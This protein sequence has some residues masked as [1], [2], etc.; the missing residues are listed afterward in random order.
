MKK[1]YILLICFFALLIP[2]Q[3]NAYQEGI[4]SFYIDATVLEDGNMHMKELI[5]L[6]GSFNG[7]D[8]IINY[9]NPYLK[10]FNG[11][12]L[13]S[14]Y[15]SDIYNGTGIE[16][17]A[18]KDI[19]V[20]ESSG[21]NAI[22]QDG[23]I[24][25]EVTSASLGDYGKYVLTNNYNGV[26][27]RIYN[28]SKGKVRGFY[29][30][31]IIQNS[32]VLHQ[33]V[34]EAYLNLFDSLTEYVGYLEMQIHIPN[35]K[36]LLR[37]WA[38]GP[39]TGEIS[40]ESNELIKVIASDISPNNPIDVRFVFDKDVIKGQNKTTSVIALEKIIAVE[41]E[42]ANQANAEREAIKLE[43]EREAIS[44]VSKAESN[45]T[46]DNYENALISINYLSEGTL[47]TELLS[48]LQL[49]LEKVEAEESK[50]RKFFTTISIAWI[51][52]LL[53]LGK[54]FYHKYD[55]E[56]KAEF[57]GTYYRDFPAEYG[58]EILA[59]LLKLDV[60]SEELSSSLMNLIYKKAILFE[61]QTVGKRNKK[62]YLL[63]PNIEGKKLTLQERELIAFLLNDKA[64][65]LDEIQK[66]AKRNYE[67]FIS[68]YQIWKEQALDA[69]KKEQF[70]ES[71]KSKKV[72]CTIYALFGFG[73]IF[74]N[75]V[76]PYHSY[77]WLNVLIIS[78]SIIGTVYFL[79]CTKKTQ[80]GTDHYHKWMGLKK[81]LKDFSNMDKRELPEVALWE[82][83]LVYAMPLGCAKKLAKDMEIRIKE[84]DQNMLSEYMF[85]I[86]YMGRMI[87]IN[88]IINQ[89]I[90]SSVSAA[91]SAQTRQQLSDISSSSSSSG[92]GFGGG[93][94]SGGGSGGGGGGG[95]RF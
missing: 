55:K 86:N 52:G 60:G 93:F 36:N 7:F 17:L 63:T 11:Q 70:Y 15:G 28:P 21:F 59:Y 50:L 85:D 46:R 80:K 61:E 1:L 69:A 79:G 3:V 89:S 29:I 41:T 90:S 6:N 16:L 34:G 72:L 5:I 65:T 9:R 64:T 48:R 75:K 22:H 91:Y 49:V 88:H 24:F 20:T 67:R 84:I 12:S 73:I 39:L 37:G 53:V 95:G 13:D 44:A 23:Y 31:Y 47:K 45:P 71:H 54:I 43:L 76:N 32:A 35:N 82:R 30:E 56:Y 14:F 33:D 58:P 92:G 74:W 66:K 83:Y 87:A 25:K 78:L 10:Q 94:S 42:R 19:A 77:N 8:R 57:K 4:T 81:F 51:L 40:L 38:H 18:I 2:Y 27:Y 68:G 26:K 62:T